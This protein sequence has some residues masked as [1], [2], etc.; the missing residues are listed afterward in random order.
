MEVT[1]KEA[2]EKRLWEKKERVVLTFVSANVSNITK[3]A[4]GMYNIHT[5]G[6]VNTVQSNCPIQMFVDLLPLGRMHMKLKRK[7]ME[8]YEACRTLDN[9]SDRRST[10]MW[11]Y[12][13]SGEQ[14]IVDA[15]WNN[16]LASVEDCDMFIADVLKE[17]KK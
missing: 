8:L 11:S 5:R 6:T 12:D 10:G 13:E 16:F 3:E 9:A 4:H 14:Y 1:V 15:D 17:K 7:F 2:Y